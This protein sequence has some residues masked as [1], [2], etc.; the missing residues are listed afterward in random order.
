MTLSKRALSI[1]KTCVRNN[2]PPHLL[3]SLLLLTGAFLVM[4]PCYWEKGQTMSF[5]LIF[6]PLPGIL[7]LTP[8][9]LPEQEQNTLDVLRM[10]STP[11]ALIFTVRA[12]CACLLLLALPAG[13]LL[14][15]G[16]LHCEIPSGLWC[17]AVCASLFLGG[18]GATCYALWE[19][20]PAAYLVPVLYFIFCA[21]TGRERM[22]EWGLEALCTATGGQDY[23]PG[24]RPA[25]LLGGIFLLAAA[26]LLR[27]R[28]KKGH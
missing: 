3:L 21:M 17:E 4:W 27:C 10:R 28:R 26:V 5:F 7:L 23:L 6:L 15:L 24:L 8:L 11:L 14:V 16:F 25:L 9:F 19:N 2:L 12:A 18:L 1:A 22:G 20:L 13:T